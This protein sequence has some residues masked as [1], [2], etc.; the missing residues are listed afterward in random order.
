MKIFKYDLHVYNSKDQILELSRGARLLSVQVQDNK[1]RLWVLLEE[2]NGIP[3]DNRHIV[4]YATGELMR[5]HS[6]MYYISTFQL[7]D[8][9][10]VYH[11]FEVE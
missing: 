3:K 6:A 1:P 4:I 9:Q 11:A 5:H 8:S 10:E 7:Y 2:S